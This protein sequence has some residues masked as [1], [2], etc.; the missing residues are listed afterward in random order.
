VSDHYFELPVRIVS[1]EGHEP[2]VA[3]CERERASCTSSAMEA[4]RRAAAKAV[5]ASGRLAED[6]RALPEQITLHGKD[7]AF[8]ARYSLGKVRSCCVCGCTEDDCRQCIA[9]TGEPCSWV[10]EDLCSACVPV[11]GVQLGARRIRR[12]RARKAVAQ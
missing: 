12:M 6:V 3:I 4:M 10:E 1:R 8:T 11:N 9:K 7:G 5:N 2:Y